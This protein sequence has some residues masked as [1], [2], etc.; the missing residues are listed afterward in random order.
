MHHLITLKVFN[1]KNYIHLKMLGFKLNKSNAGIPERFLV[2]KLTPMKL[3][4][5]L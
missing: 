3:W 4:V 2:L 1:K 5:Q